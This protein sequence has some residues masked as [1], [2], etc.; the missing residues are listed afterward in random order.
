[1]DA[2]KQKEIQEIIERSGNSF[3]SRVVRSL[4]EQQWTVLI[5]P[6]YN[7]NFTDKPREI[8]IVAEKKFAVT[9]EWNTRFFG[10]LSV[11][12]F[13]EC[14]YILGNTVFWFDAKDRIKA[15]ERAMRDTNLE[16]PDRN[17]TIKDHHYLLGEPVAK[18]FASDKSRGEENEIIAKAIN[19]NLNA[20][21]YYRN[22]REIIPSTS[23]GEKVLQ[24]IAYPLIVVN[25]FENF[26]Q[27]MVTNGGGVQPI[28]RPFQLEV[29]YAY[30]D[31][32]RKGQSEYF[33]ID[34]VSMET[35]PDFLSLLENADVNA[36]RQWIRYKPLIRQ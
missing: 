10:F 30:L 26:Y 18:L 33:L 31:N 9:D 28:Q 5:S 4:R 27:T 2:K 3:H 19:Q 35:L 17:T 14:K 36:V 1:M 23:S 34:V 21:V 8:D 25:S 24:V 13:V 32:E 7:D 16:H 12:L 22:N 20:F 29:N 15:I 11:R 6:Y